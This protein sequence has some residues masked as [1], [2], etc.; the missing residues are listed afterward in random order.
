MC[1]NSRRIPPLSAAV[2]FDEPGC[3][4]FVDIDAPARLV[5]PVSRRRAPFPW[6]ANVAANAALGVLTAAICAVILYA[7]DLGADAHNVAL[8]FAPIVGIPLVA[9]PCDLL[10]HFLAARRA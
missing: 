6:R 9:T 2:D 8:C 3:P 5:D 4:Q 10:A 1:A 7:F